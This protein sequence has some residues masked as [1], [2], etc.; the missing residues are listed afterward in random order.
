MAVARS[1]RQRWR[2]LAPRPQ[3]CG[4][5]LPGRSVHT[6]TMKEPLLVVALD[7]DGRV[8]VHRRMPP[9][10][11]FSHRLARHMLELH[12]QHLPPPVGVVLTWQGAGTADPLRHPHRQPR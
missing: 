10:R 4:L 3:T 8:V 12:H 7:G 2:G 11:I 6:F 1:F 5:L 9:R